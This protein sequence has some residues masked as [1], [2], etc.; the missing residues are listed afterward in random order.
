MVNREIYLFKK[1][2]I[3]HLS[4]LKKP[5]LVCISYTSKL[6]NRLDQLKFV[7]GSHTG[8]NVFN[9]HPQGK[10]YGF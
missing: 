7:G 10:V 1:S 2:F 4:G 5:L 6:L 9:L 3:R 8:V